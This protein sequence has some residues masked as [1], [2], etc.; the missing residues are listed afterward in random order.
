MLRLMSPVQFVARKLRVDV[1]LGDQLVRA[2]DPIVLL[3]GAANRDPAAFPHPD[4][5][6]IRREPNR[7]LAFATGI[8][9]CAG[10]SLARM[11]AQVAIAGMVRRFTIE[12]DG[13]TARS[14]RVRFRGFVRYPVRLRRV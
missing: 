7:H 6:D 1:N 10:N 14:R 11:E 2:G 12:P 3:L 5:L 13:P 9:I 4:R 8:H